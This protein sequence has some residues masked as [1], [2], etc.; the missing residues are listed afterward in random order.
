MSEE[1][2][3]SDATP[4]LLDVKKSLGIDPE[5]T[6]MDSEILMHL[7]G[8]IATLHSNGFG[9]PLFVT[10]I[11]QTWSELKDPSQSEIND[12]YFT[13]AVQ[14]IFV[15][16]KINFDPPMASSLNSLKGVRDEL[17]WRCNVEYSKPVDTTP[18]GR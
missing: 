11:N 4:I 18:E 6:T 16:V 7:N 15:D 9:L 5:D 10:G 1:P 2:V 17:L 13:L 12:Q 3:V 14:Y 8:S